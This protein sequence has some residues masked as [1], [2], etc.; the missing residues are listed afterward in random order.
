MAL[1]Q[2]VR[3]ITYKEDAPHDQFEHGMLFSQET[4]SVSHSPLLSPPTQRK[5][6]EGGRALGP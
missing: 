4:H 1:S 6:R 5:G 3:L 2:E